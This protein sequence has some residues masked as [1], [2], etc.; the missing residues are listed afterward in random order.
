MRLALADRPAAERGGVQVR[1]AGDHLRARADAE[2]G[3]DLGPNR[4]DHRAG[5]DQR[6]QLGRVEPELAD[7]HRVVVQPVEARLSVSQAPL[8]E[9]WVA[10]ARPVNRIVR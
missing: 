1:R 9:A 2:L 4:A 5:L 3:G 8:I 10:A 7:E 6:R